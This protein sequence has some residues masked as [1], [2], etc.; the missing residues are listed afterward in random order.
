ML[1]Q[2]LTLMSAL[3]SF[4]LLS[5]CGGA[6]MSG[7]SA[8]SKDKKKKD[9]AVAID[10]ADPYVV[11]GAYLTCDFAEG[12]KDV[13]CS[14]LSSTGERI[15]P[16]QVDSLDYSAS[17]DGGLPIDETHSETASWGAVWSG[18]TRISKA[19][20]NA[21][22]KSAGQDFNFSCTGVP[23]TSLPQG[24]FSLTGLSGFIQG[25]NS[26]VFVRDH[27]TK[28]DKFC[29][30]NGVP[31]SP[32][33]FDKAVAS[34]VNLKNFGQGALTGVT[35]FFNPR[36]GTPNT[37]T[38]SIAN[39]HCIYRPNSRTHHS[40]SNCSIAVYGPGRNL[41]LSVLVYPSLMPPESAAQLA[42]V[43]ACK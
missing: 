30:N 35:S 1:R 14:L 17:I 41:V 11:T 24:A 36:S 28:P 18:L 16:K 6:A 23:C 3:A 39:P 25:N 10:A 9:D 4:G 13:G 21:Y 34:Y 8:A 31:L 33:E 19:K 42:K 32:R 29:D 38:K 26:D 43:P 7:D 20:F 27:A 15:K 40:G 2:K 12:G 37:S 22:V 5:G